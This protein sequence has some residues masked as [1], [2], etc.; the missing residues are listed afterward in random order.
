ML[1]MAAAQWRVRARRSLALLS[2]IAVAVA[3]F[4]LLT[5]A[6]VT[7][8]LDA[9]GTV[10]ANYRPVY[11]I[12]V[13]P[14]ERLELERQRNLVQAGQL[15][16]MRGGITAQQWH[17]IQGDPGRGVGDVAGR[18]RRVR[19]PA[20]RADPG[21]VR[22][23]PRPGV[24]SGGAAGTADLGDRRGARPASPTGR[25]T[26][27]RPGNRLYAATV[28]DW[29]SGKVRRHPCRNSTPTAGGRR[30][31]PVVP[32]S[33]RRTWIDPTDR[34]GRFSLTCVG[35]PARRD[36]MGNRHEA[37]PSRWP[38]PV[39]FLMAAVDPDAEAAAGRAGQGR[40]LRTVL[41]SGRG[42][43]I[44]APARRDAV[45]VLGVADPRRRQATDRREAGARRAADGG[46]SSVSRPRAG[47]DD[48]EVPARLDQAAPAR[49]SQDPDVTIDGPYRDLVGRLRHPPQ[50]T[51]ED[52]TSTNTLW[53]DRSGP[54]G[55]AETAPDGDGLRAGQVP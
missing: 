34:Q 55:P 13:R 39:P 42:G 1:S 51:G 26:C 40:H 54:S 7:S 33:A 49:P 29:R 36:T 15:A 52:R 44:A 12:L 38:G 4:T 24:A 22:R 19:R 35:G 47:S 45:S 27:T 23:R 2:M 11:D 25:P 48:G 17:E 53:L 16:G 5:A 37:P 14:R 46:G 3:G 10:T 31:A 41:H 50:N 6:A 21:G 43:T 30:S 9:V 8:R 32:S 18:G 20:D 28:V